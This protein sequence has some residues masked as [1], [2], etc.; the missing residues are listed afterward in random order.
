V[1]ESKNSRIIN[2]KTKLE[3]YGR[4][5]AV[6]KQIRRP[7]NSNDY[8]SLKHCFSRLDGEYERGDFVQE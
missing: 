6:G 8:N 3:Y 4:T 7:L 2:E 1:I 5:L